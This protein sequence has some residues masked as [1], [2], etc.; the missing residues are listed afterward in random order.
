MKRYKP[1][2]DGVVLRIVW[3]GSI[4][5]FP[6][7]LYIID[8]PWTTWALWLIVDLIGIPLMLSLGLG[9]LILVA[10]WKNER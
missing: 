6:V 3:Y 7:F 1:G 5:A 8:A 4:I 2:S 10:A 9:L